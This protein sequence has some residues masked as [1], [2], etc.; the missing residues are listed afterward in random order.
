MSAKHTQGPWR[1]EFGNNSARVIAKVEHEVAS[2]PTLRSTNAEEDGNRDVMV[3]NARLVASA[4]ELLEALRGMLAMYSSDEAGGDET[5]EE[6]R[7][8]RAAIAKA[9]GK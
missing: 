8:A 1:A 5:L 3:A 6:V 4:P 9:E 2:V 7:E